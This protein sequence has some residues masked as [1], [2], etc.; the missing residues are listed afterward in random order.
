MSDKQI[1]IISIYYGF[2]EK[3][4]G[5]P[6]RVR[7]LI[8]SFSKYPNVNIILMSRDTCPPV[9]GVTHVRLTES[10]LKN[11]L[12]LRKQIKDFKPN[13]VIGHTLT[14]I[15]Y[16]LFVKIFTR[17]LIV[18]ELHGFLE[19]EGL[20]TGSIN[21]FKY[22]KSKVVY[23]ILYKLCDLITTCSFTAS[24][25]ISSH[26][27]NVLTILGGVNPDLFNDRVESTYDFRESSEDII[28]GYAGNTRTWQ[29][30]DFLV[31]CFESIYLI[32]KRF[33]LALLLSEESGLKSH[34]GI[35]IVPKVEYSEAP[36]FLASCD[37]LVIPRAENIVNKI[38]FPSKLPEYMAMGKPVVASKTSDMFEVISHLQNG[39]LYEPGNKDDFIRSILALKEN[40]IRKKIGENATL[41][42]GEDLNW[43][44]QAGILLDKLESMLKK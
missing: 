6:I 39:I 18:L 9:K 38:S 32:D 4:R 13:V 3:N 44:K 10:R 25:I 37:V 40:S 31:D 21:R 15:V 41:K 2:L 14:G 5:T 7:N 30:L 26:N 16:L 28:I 22:Y 8:D 27:K 29:G 20:F 36:H 24:K 34:P 33:K 42:I 11:F 19:E 35:K 12:L 17:I 1:R 43:H 23:A